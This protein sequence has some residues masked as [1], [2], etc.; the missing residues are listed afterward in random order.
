MFPQITGGMGLPGLVTENVSTSHCEASVCL[1]APPEW[2]GCPLTVFSAVAVD[3][4]GCAIE[5]DSKSSLE[6]EQ[7]SFTTTTR[8]RVA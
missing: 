8:L 2:D 6:E 7:V 4:E 3:V 1:T 5:N